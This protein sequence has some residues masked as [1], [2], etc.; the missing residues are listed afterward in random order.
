MNYKSLKVQSIAKYTLYLYI[1]TYENN[2]IMP[3]DEEFSKNHH[4]IGK[5]KHA[6]GEYYHFVWWL[7]KS[8]ANTSTNPDVQAAYKEKG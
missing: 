3:I 2:N 1:I 5:H 7:G 6:D 4:T 8:D